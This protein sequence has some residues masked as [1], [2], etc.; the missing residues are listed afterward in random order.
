V[1]QGTPK[2]QHDIA[3]GSEAMPGRLVFSTI[4]EAENCYHNSS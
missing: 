2:Q 3:D 1:Y 4:N